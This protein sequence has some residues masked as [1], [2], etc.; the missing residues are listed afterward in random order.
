M[1]IHQFFRMMLNLVE[2]GGMFEDT[3]ATT[4]FERYTDQKITKFNNKHKILYFG[5]E[6]PWHWYR[7][8]NNW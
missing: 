5:Q 7:L 3:T 1:Y 8:K 2:N 6:N 4:V